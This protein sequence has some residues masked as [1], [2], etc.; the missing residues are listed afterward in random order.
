MKIFD[1]AFDHFLD[2]NHLRELGAEP[3]FFLDFIQLKLNNQYRMHFWHPSLPSFGGEEE[4]HDHRY[5][6]RSRILAGSM[7]HEE[8]RFTSDP[9][10][11]YEM[12]EKSCEPG[13]DEFTRQI[14]VGTATQESVFN[15]VR[16]SDY[17]L[18]HEAFHR[19]KTTRCVTL[20][21][22][23][24]IEK[25]FAKIIRKRGADVFCPFETKLTQT[26]MWEVIADL[27]TPEQT[28]PPGYHLREISKGVFG[29]AS[30]I[31]EEAAEFGE[32]LEQGSK[33]MALIEL[34]DMRGAIQGWLGNHYPQM[35]LHDLEAGVVLPGLK[36]LLDAVETYLR[37]SPKLAKDDLEIFSQITQRAFRNGRR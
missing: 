24:P 29:E 36:S 9:D 18:P 30:K 1:G 5:Y 32:A 21:D 14:A 11:E 35:S 4:L 17:F 28:E 27:L 6:F 22:R 3:H 10:G 8:W 16:G 33:L 31:L 12:V 20:L 13:K 23:G 34:S 2:I 25:D 7:S 19:I 37:A 26:F 15:L